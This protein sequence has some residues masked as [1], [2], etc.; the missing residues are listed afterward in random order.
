[1]AGN[2]QLVVFSLDD[3]QYGL[4][5]TCV[6]RIIRAVE[7]TYLPEA[8]DGV[9]GIINV[10]GRVIPVLSTRRK[11]GLPEKELELQ[12]LFIIVTEAGVSFALVADE[13]KPVLE[14][15]HD[16]LVGA[17]RLLPGGSPVDS[18]AKVDQGMIVV[19][20]TQGVFSRQDSQ[21]LISR[22]TEVEGGFHARGHP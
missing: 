11:L 16:Q 19:L 13:V 12:D 18:V 10:E 4:N 9:L 14:L 17:E 22:L 7:I 3:Q 20:T 2:S 5:L 15:P 6:E 1:M 21:F 8:P